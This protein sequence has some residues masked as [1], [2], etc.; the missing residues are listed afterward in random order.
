[1]ESSKSSVSAVALQAIELIRQFPLDYPDCFIIEFI[2]FSIC[3]KLVS[4]YSYIYSNI[5][6]ID[7]DHIVAEGLTAIRQFLTKVKHCLADQNAPDNLYS[8]KSFRTGVSVSNKATSTD[9]VDG[10]PLAPFV[11]PLFGQ[12]KVK[13]LEVKNKELININKRI[14]NQ[15]I[16]LIHL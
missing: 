11:S 16:H 5:D 1:M 12:E 9:A 14:I 6:I 13:Q 7:T 4:M 15:N 10:I 3:P 8:P 2:Q